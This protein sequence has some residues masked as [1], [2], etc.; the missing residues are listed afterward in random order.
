[1][2]KPKILFLAV[3]STLLVMV[4]TQFCHGQLQFPKTPAP[5][6]LIQDYANIV[7]D[8]DGRKIAQIQYESYS[9]FDT[10]IV[11][12]TID[13]KRKFNASREGIEKIAH[14]LFD[15]WQIG[16]RDKDDN[17]I[18]QGILLLV[19]VRDRK[20]RIELG[21]DWGRAWDNRCDQIMQGTIVKRFKQSDY[22]GGILAGV[23]KLADMGEKGPDSSP[24]FSLMENMDEPI[25]EASPISKSWGLLIIG[26]GI[27]LVVLGFALPKFRTALIATGV[28]LILLTLLLKA[29]LWGIAIIMV[30]YAPVSYTHLTLPTKA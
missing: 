26:T 23:K 27:L 7:N 21:D 30:I 9:K 20:A 10:P 15:H 5:G 19:S 28:S 14:D 11:V 17:L 18:N 2:F 13:S 16:K 8:E 4:S 25:T 1:M 29:I 22:S 6:Q 3:A 12:V 24:G